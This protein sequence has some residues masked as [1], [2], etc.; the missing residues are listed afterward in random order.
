MAARR[1]S[2]ILPKFLCDVH[3][4]HNPAWCVDIYRPILSHTSIDL[5]GACVS[6]IQLVP[7]DGRT[8]GRTI[9]DGWTDV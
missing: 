3:N 1:P 4:R 7:T 9:K 2:C 5:I 6:E 8:D